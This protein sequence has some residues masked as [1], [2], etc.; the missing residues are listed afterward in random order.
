MQRSMIG[1][2]FVRL[3]IA[4]G[5]L[6]ALALAPATSA[7]AA[8]IC[9]TIIC[10]RPGPTVTDL[11][12]GT[13][14]VTHPAAINNATK[15]VGMATG[16]TFVH[17][18]AWQ[19]GTLTDL[20]TLATDAVRNSM[21][22]GL[23]QA[24][25]VVGWSETN[26]D[27]A[28]SAF[29]VRNGVMSLVFPHAAAFGINSS[30]Q[31]AGALTDT[32]GVHH[33][34]MF[35][36]PNLQYA[37]TPPTC[38]DSEAHGINDSGLIAITGLCTNGHMHAFTSRNGVLFDLGG[39]YDG[40]SSANGINGA[41]EVAGDWTESGFTRGVIWTGGHIW[42]LFPLPGHVSSSANA[43][44]S[45]GRVVGFS[46]DSAGQKHAVIWQS[47]GAVQDLTA[48]LSAGSGWILQTATGI[49]DGGQIVGEGLHN[50]VPHGYLF[51]PAPQPVVFCC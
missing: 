24:G 21:A 51:T 34:V 4:L 7:S 27:R 18:F 17:A 14:L 1:A 47:G 20:G 10:A 41:G 32:A 16:A 42:S 38:R 9:I 45:Y 22:L 25:D 39:P 13:T 15:V 19:S 5:V 31:I 46:T 35:Q 44:N 28:D 8:G 3:A 40:D 37:G 29:V 49:N 50:G 33:A 48:Q 23:N 12:V 26:G 6:A 11:D 36:A 30:N 43:I 2:R